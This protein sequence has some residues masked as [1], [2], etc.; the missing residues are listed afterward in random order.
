M[1]TYSEAPVVM[2]AIS[3]LDKMNGKIEVFVDARAGTYFGADH[4]PMRPA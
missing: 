3:L 4:L 1:G 2:H